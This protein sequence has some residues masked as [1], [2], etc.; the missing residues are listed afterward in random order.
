LFFHDAQ[1]F[2]HFFVGFGAVAV[3]EGRTDTVMHV[4]LENLE[5]DGAQGR[6][7]G[8]D[9]GDDLN[10]VFLLFDHAF[11]ALSLTGNPRKP[12]QGFLVRGAVFCV[13]HDPLIY[14]RRVHG[15]KKDRFYHLLVRGI[16]GRL[17]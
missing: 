9:L 8:L 12:V 15:N 4:F 17:N 3:S 2:V 6:A 16:G 5:F 1:Q 11:D 10:A 13:C 7:G 14:P